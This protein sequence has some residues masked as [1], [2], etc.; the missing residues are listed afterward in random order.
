MLRTFNVP[1]FQTLNK[2]INQSKKLF[3]TTKIQNYQKSM[4]IMNK[5]PLHDDPHVTDNTP[6]TDN[7]ATQP[8]A[9]TT[10]M[11]EQYDR[12]RLFDQSNC[13]NVN[14][15]TSPE[16]APKDLKFK[17]TW[18]NA[19][20][21]RQKQLSHGKIIDS[22]LY[23]NVKSTEIKDKTRK[24]SF[25][26]LYLPFKED[27]LIADFYV[28]AGGRIRMGLVFQDLDALAARI[29]Y[30]HCSPSEP[31]IVT[32]SVDRI[33]MLQ[34][35]DS[36]T[37][38]NLVLSGSV[39]WTGRSSMEITVKATAVPKN[40]SV[41]KETT[42]NADGTSTEE[43]HIT[44]EFLNNPEFQTVLMSS[45]TFVARNPET[46]KS[47]AINKLLPI[48]EK[49]W[50]DYKRAESHNVAKKLR[51]KNE[52]LKQNASPTAEESQIIH[53]LYKANE[54]IQGLSTPF[55][56]MMKDCC[57]K[58][59][60]F[61]QPQFR[62]RHSF[63]CFGGALM[64]WTFELAYCTTTS[65]SHGLPRFL[66]LDATTFKAPVPIGS[67]LHLDSKVVYSEHISKSG[68]P[69]SNSAIEK[70]LPLAQNDP[71]NFTSDGTVI[72]VKVDT[73]VQELQSDKKYS[74]GSFIY[75]FFVPKQ[76]K[77]AE[78]FTVLPES[79]SDYIEY[80]EARRRT[81]DSANYGENAKRLAKL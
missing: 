14:K 30:R 56:K 68:N 64:K 10:V 25:S 50:S 73:T 61:V 39:V 21:E 43:P 7:A 16:E 54:S 41:P 45:F 77:D 33:F 34:H 47:L 74:S 58:S 66:S 3:S 46:H 23:N 78:D 79:Y 18:L 53:N 62:N 1:R 63:Q 20:K 65:V 38:A 2:S 71:K 76:D 35:M 12:Q 57:F 49:E 11:T 40:V 26:Y 19:I 5:R 15:A 9:L 27:P 55:V 17:A 72:Q 24:D 80:I 67:I 31:I 42:T 70:F 52:N 29:A 4:V 81:A 51:A 60:M 6:G 28:N 44:E 32:A 59:T 8:D 13:A 75:S 48:N 69:N 36:I 37:D 22:Y